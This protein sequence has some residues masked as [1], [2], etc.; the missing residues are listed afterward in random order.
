MTK[1]VTAKSFIINDHHVDYDYR[2]G[3]INNITI[4]SP[5]QDEGIIFS[6]SPLEAK[7]LWETLDEMQVG[8]L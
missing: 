6:G 7:T 5:I 4:F 2:D 8:D 1:I 3:E